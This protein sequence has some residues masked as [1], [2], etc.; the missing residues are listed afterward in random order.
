MN[1][2]HQATSRLHFSPIQYLQLTL[3]H[4]SIPTTFTIRGYR[5]HAL[6]SIESRG[7][8]VCVTQYQERF[9]RKHDKKRRKRQESHWRKYMGFVKGEVKKA[10]SL[11]RRTLLEEENYR[12]I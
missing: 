9:E 11:K 12:N 8:T 10:W 7:R 6:Q 2:L 1:C 4:L 5:K 3:S